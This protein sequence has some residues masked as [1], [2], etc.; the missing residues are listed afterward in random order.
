M[1]KLTHTTDKI[2]LVLNETAN[3]QLDCYASFKEWAAGIKNVSDRTVI[4]T[5]STTPIDLVR[6][7]ALSTLQIDVDAI[8]IFNSDNI[9]HL[10]SILYNVNGTT[11]ILWKGDLP[12]GGRLEYADKRGWSVSSPNP[13]GY[14]INVQALTV[15]PTDGQTVYFGM[16]PKAPITTAG[17]SKIYIRKAG[18]LKV[19]EI[20][21]YSGTAGTA[22]NWS[23]YVRKNNT[24][25]YLI[26]TLGVSANERVFSNTGLNIPLAVGDF[27]EIKDVQPTWATNPATCIRGGYIYIE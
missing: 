2:Q 8:S 3:T 15:T 19:A 20:Y 13:F 27:I 16:L 26:A 6:V 10:V 11:G 22:E 4:K 12:S 17:A 23:S 21:C 25:D 24:T 7:P 9:S 1:I 14:A 5:Q 18:T